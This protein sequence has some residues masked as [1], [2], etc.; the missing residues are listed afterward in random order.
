MGS[1]VE[2]DLLK[3]VIIRIPNLFFLLL[4]LLT[5]SKNLRSQTIAFARP[6]EISQGS[7]SG[8]TSLDAAD[9]NLDGL[10][11]V[12]ILEGGKHAE[13]PTFAW[14]EQKSRNNWVRH[15]LGNI[16]QVDSFLGSAKCADMDEDG[17]MDVVF[18]SDNHTQGPIKV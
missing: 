1:S 4:A 15:E 13:K 11:D 6:V 3:P 16:K 10:L 2:T 17:D 18:T 14:F 5:V 7:V 12:L 8:V 9:F